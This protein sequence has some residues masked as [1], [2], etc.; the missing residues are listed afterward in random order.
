MRA[1]L[2]IILLLILPTTTTGFVSHS[3]RPHSCSKH[4]CWASSKQV[5]SSSRGT[6]K[7]SEIMNVLQT[8]YHN[9]D[10]STAKSEWTK[11]RNY[12]YQTSERLTLDQVNDVL[13]VL[14]KGKVAVITFH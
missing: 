12:L 4:A 3:T 5:P 6:S 11:T 8:R 9:N 2:R 10:G 7:V 13:K 1:H 14:D